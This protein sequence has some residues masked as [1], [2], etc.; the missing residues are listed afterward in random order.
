M[1]QLIE[2]QDVLDL[3]V[4]NQELLIKAYKD[5]NGTIRDLKENNLLDISIFYEQLR[6]KYNHGGS[7]IYINIMK[8]IEEPKKVLT[9]L[10]ALITQ[11]MLYS[12]Q[13]E[14]R[15]IFLKHSK[16]NDILASINNY[17]TTGDL[18]GCIRTIQSI[19][20]DIKYIES[21]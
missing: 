1:T 11:I 2:K 19:K 18:I 21:I 3:A 15:S 9:T 16:I 7:K 10:S 4:N 20:H 14:N 6:Y 8:E 13:C 17:I 5:F 12:E